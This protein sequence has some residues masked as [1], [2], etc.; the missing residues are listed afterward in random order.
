[1]LSLKAFTQIGRRLVN[2]DF[3]TV[4]IEGVVAG[5]GE[6]GRVE[7]MIRVRS[8]ES[9]S[10]PLILNLTRSDTASFERELRST[11]SAALSDRR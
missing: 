9:E 6:A 7:M 8:G 4:F 3:P 2:E 11:L 10:D 1:M 5:D